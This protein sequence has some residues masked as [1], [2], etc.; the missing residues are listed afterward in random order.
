MKG[1]IG[2]I[3]ACL[4]ELLEFCATAIDTNVPPRSSPIKGAEEIGQSLFSSDIATVEKEIFSPGWGQFFPG[5]DA[6]GQTA[7]NP[8][9]DK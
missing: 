3:H 7:V 4:F 9:R 5:L 6:F 1:N 8:I 2:A